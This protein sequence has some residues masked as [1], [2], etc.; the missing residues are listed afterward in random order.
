MERLAISKQAAQDAFEDAKDIVDR[1][2]H[3]LQNVLNDARHAVKRRPAQALALAFAAGALV[4][5]V[6]SRNG[7]R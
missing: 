1:A 6:V 5:V 3:N 7:K 4:G 2:R